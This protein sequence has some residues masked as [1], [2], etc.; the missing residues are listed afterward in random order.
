MIQKPTKLQKQIQYSFN[1]FVPL[2]F[3]REREMKEMTTGKYMENSPISKK[4]R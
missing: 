1:Q 2:E 3:P 4:R